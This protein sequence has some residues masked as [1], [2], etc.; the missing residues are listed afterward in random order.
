MKFKKLIEQVSDIDYSVIDH[1]LAKAGRFHDKKVDAYEKEVK[2]LKLEIPTDERDAHQDVVTNSELKKMHLSESLFESLIEE[3]VE[4]RS[5]SSKLLDMIYEGILDATTV[6]LACIKY[7]SEDDVADMATLNGFLDGTEDGEILEEDYDGY[8]FQ[9]PF[10][11]RFNKDNLSDIKEDIEVVLPELVVTYQVKPGVQFKDKQALN[12]LAKLELSSESVDL[13]ESSYKKAIRDA[14][15]EYN[16]EISGSNLVA[17]PSPINLVSKVALTEGIDTNISHAEEFIKAL[18]SAGFGDGFDQKL[19]IDEYSTGTRIEYKD[20]G[21]HFAVVIMEDKIT[22]EGQDEGEQPFKKEFTNW[23]EFAKE[24]Q[25]LYPGVPVHESN[26]SLNE[27]KKVPAMINDYEREDGARYM[28]YAQ[29]EP[30][31]YVIEA[32]LTSGEI[33]YL[34]KNGKITQSVLPHKEYPVSQ[35]SVQ[36]DSWDMPYVKVW[37]PNKEYFDKAIEVAKKYGKD[38]EIHTEKYVQ[39]PRKFW[40]EIIVDQEDTEEPYVDPNAPVVNFSSKNKG[41]ED[42]SDELTGRHM[43][44]NEDLEDSQRYPIESPAPAQTGLLFEDIDASNIDHYDILDWLSEHEQAEQDAKSF[45][46]PKELYDVTSQELVDWIF[47][48]DQLLMDFQDKFRDQLINESK[49]QEDVMMNG[50]LNEV[51]I[52][53]EGIRNFRPWGTAVQ[54]FNNILEAGKMDAFEAS[55]E[56][57][58]Q[59]GIGATE[60]NDILTFSAQE[61]YAELG[62]TEYLDKE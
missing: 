5:V 53:T 17:I 28:V 19:I 49:L 1:T 42:I 24:F 41:S 36:W 30:L 52:S 6:V 8:V 7:M 60:L 2:K 46:A 18:R 9:G 31:A 27:A 43:K 59:N 51:R 35:V 26:K 12:S 50:A 33:C 4:I 48:H 14:V 56:E 3:D 34:D 47:D 10:G 13:I 29:R 23:S 58:H 16:V 20:Q 44:D 55:L 11:D 38:Y 25:D 54:V 21:G 37:G 39:G 22:L 62:M 57:T 32:E 61:L 15:P 40:L 45:F